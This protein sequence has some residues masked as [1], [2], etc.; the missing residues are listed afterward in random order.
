MEEIFGEKPSEFFFTITPTSQK[1]LL[2]AA[3][4]LEITE[5]FL[6]EAIIRVGAG[7]AIEYYLEKGFN[8]KENKRFKSLNRHG[9]NKS[10][11][12]KSLSL[13]NYAHE[14]LSKYASLLNESR[15]EVLE[16][17]I[18][19]KTAIIEATEFVKFLIQQQLT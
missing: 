17:A 14:A 1:K 3:K 18:R 12:H 5:S 13:T 8:T 7:A 4:K 2:Q 9:E 11:R 6:V 16:C 15:S 10:K 19:S